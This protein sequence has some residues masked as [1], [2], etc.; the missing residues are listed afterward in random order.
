MFFAR[1]NREAI[2]S[3]SGATDTSTLSKLIGERW[4]QETERGRYEQLAA[5]DRV[6]HDK[7]MAA[8]DAALAREH[9]AERSRAAAAA[10]GPSEREVE[11]AEKRDRLEREHDERAAAPK[12][13]KKARVLTE[14]QRTIA[15]NNAIIETDKAAA[16]KQRLNFLLGQSDLFKHFGMVRAHSQNVSTVESRP[17]FAASPTLK[18]QPRTSTGCRHALLWGWGGLALARASACCFGSLPP[19]Q[20]THTPL[21]SLCR[22]PPCLSDTPCVFRLLFARGCS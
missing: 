6:R 18:V 12:K 21:G 20:H 10:S 4:S 7:E 13:E 19:F 14:E 3:E 11:R 16:A 1:A 2:S 8:Y 22:T 5:Q 15:A 9:T 17:R